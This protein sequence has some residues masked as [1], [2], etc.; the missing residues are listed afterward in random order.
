MTK[1]TVV[2]ATIG[3]IITAYEVVGYERP[4]PELRFVERSETI[5]GVDRFGNSCGIGS[6]RIRILQQKW[7]IEAAQQ[8][9]E[10]WRDVPLAT[11]DS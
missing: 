3:P 2:D 10:E 1:P 6:K 9:R 11:E 8:V 7:I 5:T 4:T